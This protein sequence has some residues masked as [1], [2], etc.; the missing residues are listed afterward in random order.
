[1]SRRFERR[2][3]AV[4][5]DSPSVWATRAEADFWRAVSKAASNFGPFDAELTAIERLARFTPLEHMAWELKFTG[6]TDLEGIL[7]NVRL[8]CNISSFL[9]VIAAFFW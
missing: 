9:E 3:I 2:V 7:E 1:M 8:I 4:E 5:A 6:N